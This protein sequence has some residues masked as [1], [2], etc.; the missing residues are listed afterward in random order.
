MK[1]LLSSLSVISLLFG[2]VPAFAQEDL[3]G[4]G[5]IKITIEGPDGSEDLTGHWTMVRP[6]NQRTEGDDAEFSFNE[7]D[8]GV[9][10]F[11]IKLPEGTTAE[12]TV[13]RD[14]QRINTVSIPQYTV[15][16]DGQENYQINAKLSFGV[17][18]TVAV[19]STPKGLSYTL[20]GPNG[21][22]LTGVTPESYEGFPIGQY[23]AY[24]DDIE[25][26]NSFP[27]QSDRLVK[28]S[29]I[30][31]GVNVVCE[32]LDETDLGIKEQHSIEFV[33]VTIEGNQVTFED[34]RTAEW[35]APYVTRVAKAAIITGYK[36]R[37]GIAN[38]QFGPGNNVTIAELA[39]IAHELGGINESAARSDVQ[40]ARAKGQ[41]FEQY[42]A[43]AEQRWWE[44]WRNTNLDPSRPATRAEVIVT[45]LRALNVDR[46]WAQGKIFGDVA[47]TVRYAASIETA[48]VDGLIDSGGLFRPTD[49]INRAEIAKIIANAMD[50]YIE[51]T[52]ETQGNSW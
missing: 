39:K 18:G 3:Q 13:L 37:H 1:T 48:A 40:N 32:N 11:S 34:V 7:V 19:N 52:A 17:A 49:P 29:R 21:M 35:F 38:G 26:C 28:D 42:F 15:H 24:F 51:D 47:P 6:G 4:V 2:V 27:P 14:G 10:I 30:T 9:Y 20:K 12:I 43:S 23:A 33:T 25:G 41:W 36:D 5:S 31:L 50:L 44:L 22:E 46:V 16:L 8:A 45:L